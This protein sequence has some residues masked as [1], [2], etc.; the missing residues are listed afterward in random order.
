[1]NPT[2]PRPSPPPPG[3][4]GGGLGGGGRFRL[5]PIRA[6][7][8]VLVAMAVP[9]LAWAQA[10]RRYS[11][12]VEGVDLGSGVVVVE[13]LGRKGQPERHEVRVGPETPILSV[14]RL[15]PHAMRGPN[16]YGEMPVTAADLLVGDYVVVESEERDGRAVALRITI[17]EIP[18][19]VPRTP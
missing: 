17:V 3:G 15:R 1:V 6:V 13:E 19:S 4:W 14:G 7:A 11:G 2:G 10:P 18:A 5:T 12:K 16:A 9:V 8:V